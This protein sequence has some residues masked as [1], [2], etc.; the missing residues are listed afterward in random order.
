MVVVPNEAFL[1]GIVLEYCVTSSSTL[2]IKPEQALYKVLVSIEETG[3][4]KEFPG[5][6]KGKEG[7]ALTFYSRET[8]STEFYGKRIKA[9]VTY[10]GD[11]KGGFY[12]IKQIEI[13]Q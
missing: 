5:F 13:V 4:V 2:G 6:L 11:E 1:K 9:L 3:A 8:M 7:Q 12:W 10:E